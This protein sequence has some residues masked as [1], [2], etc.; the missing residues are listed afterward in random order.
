MARCSWIQN[1]IV[2]LLTVTILYTFAF[3]ITRHSCHRY[4]YFKVIVIIAVVFC[5]IALFL[6]F[7]RLESFL[8]VFRWFGTF[9]DKMVFG[10]ASKAF[11]SWTVWFFFDEAPA[12]WPFSF[13]FLLFLK[14]FSTEWL[15]SPQ[16]VHFALAEFP[17]SL[18]L[19]DPERL[20]S[21]FKYYVCN[22]EIFKNLLSGY[23][24]SLLNYAWWLANWAEYIPLCWKLS[25]NVFII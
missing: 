21:R 9:C 8:T 10:S 5:T 4:V 22:D 1:P 20:L 3:V 19:I 14:L 2:Q 13:S 7:V 15:V 25:R 18:C 24:Y 11:P 6:S 16:Y 23:F 17:F 12:E